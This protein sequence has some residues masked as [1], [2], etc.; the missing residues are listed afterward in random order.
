MLVAAVLLLFA[1]LL[2]P[3]VCANAR[4][5]NP[6]LVTVVIVIRDKAMTVD[7]MIAI[8]LPPPNAGDGIEVSVLNK[9]QDTK[10]LI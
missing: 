1:V 9:K 5:S 4:L 6:L 8:L 10:L 3:C 7:N 2:L